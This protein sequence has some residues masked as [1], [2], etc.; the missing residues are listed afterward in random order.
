MS[1]P[2]ILRV[3]QDFNASHI[4]DIPTRI[5]Q[6]MAKLNL[7]NRNQARQYRG[8][9]RWESWSSQYR[10]HPQ[11][12]GAGIAKAGCSS[13]RDSSY[14]KSRWRNGGG[15]AGRVGTLWYYRKHHGSSN[16]GQYGDF[17][18]GRDSA[19]HT[20]FRD[21]YALSADH[22]AVVNRIKPHT[23]FDGEIESGLTKMMVIGLGKQTGA[24]HYHRANLRYGY[25]TVITS[26]AEVVKRNCKILFVSELLRMPMMKRSWSKDS[27]SGHRVQREAAPPK[28]PSPLSLVFLLIREMCWS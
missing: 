17:A 3:Q 5:T 25:Y 21:N 9:D 24:I 8:S 10:A 4:T 6:E 27:L 18:G 13:V 16:Q 12:C 11:E 19:R 20:R 23:D 15:P 26:V 22:I 7:G 2:R 14:G 28:S 1:F